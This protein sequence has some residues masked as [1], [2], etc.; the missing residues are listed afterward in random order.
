MLPQCVQSLYSEAGAFLHKSRNFFFTGEKIS[1]QF[2]AVYQQWDCEKNNPTP[3]SPVKWQKKEI[4]AEFFYIF[5]KI[6]VLLASKP[7]KN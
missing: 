3:F 6:K 7:F 4:R 1:V 2:H 5:K